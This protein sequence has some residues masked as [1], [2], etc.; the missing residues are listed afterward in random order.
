MQ[1]TPAS[2]EAEIQRLARENATLRRELEAGRRIGATAE[3]SEAI[4]DAAFDQAPHFAGL[5]ALDGVLLHA[6]RSACAFIGRRAA[7]VVGRPFWSTPWWAHSPEEQEKLR[8]AIVKAAQGASVRFETTNQAT[9]G[10]LHPI[11]F[12]L[13]PA[14]DKEGLAF[15]L[16]VEGWDITERKEALAQLRTLAH[17]QRVIL[18]TLTAGLCRIKK[19]RH[20]W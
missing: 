15:A 9:D 1:N 6:N 14:W 3:R 2:L 16:I 8:G 17:E 5:L 19:R 10:R 12:T 18:D 11:D 20:Q 13:R 4:F 7:E